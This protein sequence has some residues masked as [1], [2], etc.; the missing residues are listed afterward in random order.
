MHAFANELKTV[1]DLLNEDFV[2]GSALAVEVSASSEANVRAA[3]SVVTENQGL[4]L[5]FCREESGNYLVG[6][7]EEAVA[8]TN[9]MV[10]MAAF[11]PEGVTRPNSTYNQDQ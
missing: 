10:T 6:G 9:V 3:V 7:E 8:A 4:N 1:V 11:D 5:T 2:F